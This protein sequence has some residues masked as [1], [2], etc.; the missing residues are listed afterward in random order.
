MVNAVL[1]IIAGIIF[2]AY[3]V[4]FFKIMKGEPQEF[5]KEIVKI[6]AE[7]IVEKKTAAK[8][9]I[10]FLIFASLAAEILYF[11]LVFLVMTNPV[12]IGFTVFFAVIEMLHIVKISTAF[13]RFFKGI[14][15]LKDVFNWRLERISAMF[16]F[17]HS[18][19]VLCSIVLC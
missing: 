6:L 17:T 5:E 2:V 16:F 12:I 1:G 15:K 8:T 13:H 9:Q 3:S 7:W 19:L 18:L 14:I 10:G 11:L 4:Y